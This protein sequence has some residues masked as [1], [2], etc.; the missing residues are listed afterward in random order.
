MKQRPI[1]MLTPLH[2]T[3]FERPVWIS[4]MGARSARSEA[5]FQR[6]LKQ[7]RKRASRRPVH[8]ALQQQMTRIK[9][10]EQSL[11]EII[12][13]S[14]GASERCTFAD[15]QIVAEQALKPTHR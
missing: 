8:M 1:T 10:L 4:Q 15:I 12:L 11:E 3:P 14:S 9:S 2:M 7:I 13:I 6:S 5:I